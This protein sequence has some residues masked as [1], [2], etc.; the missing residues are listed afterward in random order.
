MGCKMDNKEL[1]IYESAVFQ[2]SDDG[3]LIRAYY[4]DF[5]GTEVEMEE[6]EAK[7]QIAF[8]NYIQKIQGE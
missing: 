1:K 7:N 8:M 2:Y 3:K 5:D 6:A 4:K